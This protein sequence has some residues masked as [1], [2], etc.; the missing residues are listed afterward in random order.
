MYIV[1]HI[2]IVFSIFL[3]YM[4]FTGGTGRD[5]GLIWFQIFPLLTFAINGL[6]VGVFMVAFYIVLAIV[7]TVF[8]DL[9][10]I[11]HDYPQNVIYSFYGTTFFIIVASF[12]SEYSRVKAHMLEENFRHVLVERSERDELTGS[13]NRRHMNEEI[14]NLFLQQ[15]SFSLAFADVDNFKSINDNYGHDIGDEVIK[16]VSNAFQESLRNDDYLARWG[17]EEFILLL[18]TQNLG[19]QKL[20]LNEFESILKVSKLM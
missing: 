20:L 14:K 11:T 18:K 15:K 17:G 6:T 7:A 9:P 4:V 3:C 19:L 12:I 5:T 10:F 1:W 8:T 13:Y 16:Q 2:N